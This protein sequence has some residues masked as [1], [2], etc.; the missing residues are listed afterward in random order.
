MREQK[1][2]TIFVN[3]KL[4]LRYC[5]YELNKE[6]LKLELRKII[7]NHIM[8]IYLLKLA[9]NLEFLLCRIIHFLHLMT[10]NNYMK[11]EVYNKISIQIFHSV[12]VV[13][14]TCQDF[15]SSNVCSPL[16]VDI[17]AL[18]TDAL[19]LFSFI[20]PYRSSLAIYILRD[21]PYCKKSEHQVNVTNEK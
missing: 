2:A 7:K 16:P 8:Y 11:R 15:Q 6:F 20:R 19:A 21:L 13:H 17:C 5:K 12:N 10:V 9:F 3:T 18:I 14:R 1:V 4:D